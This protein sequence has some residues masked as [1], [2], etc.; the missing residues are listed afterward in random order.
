ME[1]I[2]DANNKEVLC[3]LINEQEKT[4]FCLC[5]KAFS[6]ADLISFSIKKLNKN[7]GTLVICEGENIQEIV[8]I[9]KKELLGNNLVDKF[10]NFMLG[11]YSIHVQFRKRDDIDT[12]KIKNILKEIIETNEFAYD[13]FFVDENEEKAK[14]IILNKLKYAKTYKDIIG[15]FSCTAD[16]CLDSL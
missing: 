5:K 9:E 13:Y 11:A 2:V 15:I 7:L 10:K 3:L 8:H 6:V 14:Q 1:K 16:K 12:D 4:I